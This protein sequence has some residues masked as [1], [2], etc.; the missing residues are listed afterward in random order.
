[1]KQDRHDTQDD[2][3]SQEFEENLHREIRRNE[4]YRIVLELMFLPLLEFGKVLLELFGK[5]SQ[6]NQSQ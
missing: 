1:M 2:G 6:K 5:D 4:T 3:T